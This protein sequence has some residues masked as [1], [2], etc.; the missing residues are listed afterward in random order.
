MEVEVQEAA[1][2][3]LLAELEEQVIQVVVLQVQLILVVVE[4][5]I[6]LVLTHVIILEVQE[7]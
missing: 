1:E 6:G 7:L 2:A 4:V 3:L 5:E